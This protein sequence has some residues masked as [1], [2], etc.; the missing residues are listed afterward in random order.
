MI[1]TAVAALI[2]GTGAIRAKSTPTAGLTEQSAAERAGKDPCAHA[3]ESKVIRTYDGAL[4]SALHLSSSCGAAPRHGATH[5]SRRR[6]A[7]LL[8]LIEGSQH[9]DSDAQFR[10]LNEQPVISVDTK[11]KELVGEFKNSGRQWRPTGGPVAVHVHDFADP[12][13]G[14]AIPNGI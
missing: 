8:R 3:A 5:T 12:K 2:G 7:G 4:R 11:K 1:I 10:Y 14:K 6:V 9:P 13:L